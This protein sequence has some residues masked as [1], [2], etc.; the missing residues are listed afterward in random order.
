MH[1]FSDRAM[2]FLW[3]LFYIYINGDHGL[4]LYYKKKEE[5]YK[6]EERRK[7]EERKK[8][9]ERRKKER[10][11]WASITLNP[12]RKAH[13]CATLRNYQTISGVEGPLVNKICVQVEGFL[14]NSF[15]DK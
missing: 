13:K 3:M 4:R 11:K 8:K 12:N 9:E 10:K 5:S 14:V 15:W 7:K 6:K 1:S 2:V